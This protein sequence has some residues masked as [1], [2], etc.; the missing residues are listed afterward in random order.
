MSWNHAESKRF[1][2]RYRAEGIDRDIAL[3][4]YSARL[5]GSD[6]TLV[7]HGGGNSSVKTKYQDPLGN[8]VDAIHVKGSGWDMGNIEPEG[9]PT[10]DLNFLR[11]TQNLK[12]LSDE[13]MVSIMRRACFDPNSPDPSVETLLHAF[14]PHKYVDHTH[15][16]SV[17][18]LANMPNAMDICKELYGDSVAILPWIMPG[19]KL[20]QACNIAYMKNP[21]IIGIVLLNH[22]IFSFGGTAK[23]S[24]ERMIKLV[25]KAETKINFKLKKVREVKSKPETLYHIQALGASMIRK[26]L[27]TNEVKNNK[28]LV[29]FIDFD[30]SMNFIKENKSKK[31][32]GYGVITPDHVIRIKSKWLFSKSLSTNNK[33]SW[34][35]SFSKSLKKYKK[36]YTNYFNKNN[37]NEL[38][39]LDT[40]PR[41][42]FIENIGLYVLGFN[43][44]EIKINTDLARA[45]IS[46]QLL[47]INSGGF[48]PLNERKIFEMEYWSLEQKKLGKK[49]ISQFLGKVIVVTGGAGVIGLETA[50]QFHKKGAEVVL[51]D[52]NK[53]A[54]NTIHDQ[55][56]IKGFVCDLTNKKMVKNTLNRILKSYGVINTLVMNS[57][58]AIEGAIDSID[59]IEIEKS[60]DNNF[61]A[62]QNIASETVKIMKDQDTKGCLLFNITKQVFN[63]GKDFGAYGISKSAMLSLM[64]QYAIEC[65]EY[66]IRSNGVNPDKIRSNLLTPS[67]ISTRSKSRSISESKYMTSNL[68]SREVKARDVAEAFVYLASAESTTGM[69]ITVDGGNVP[70]FVR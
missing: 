70:S 43:E 17:L 28:P 31:L 13:D 27:M 18:V 56:G 46:T 23:E 33:E 49:T 26:G 53:E 24:Y 7:L 66:G 60:F 9:F 51:I 47:G 4:V 44:K 29:R 69:V 45:N 38:T 8:I 12:I 42:I 14:L 68:L 48:K 37:K 61:W 10:L 55:Y 62:H 20:A 21:N 64:R 63:Q 39:M 34:L 2:S 25:K 41:L 50:L 1:I 11:E 19:F 35:N 16:N 32:S 52:I 65:G 3:R 59:D 54:L 22:G 5:L 67:M 58:I 15:S 6:S 40:F 30:L 57:G 36:D